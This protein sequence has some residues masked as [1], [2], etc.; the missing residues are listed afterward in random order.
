MAITHIAFPATP[1]LAASE[2]ALVG[3][4]IV[5]RSPLSGAEQ[6][7]Q[8]GA[9]RW[10][11]RYETPALPEGG[12]RVWRAF[13]ASLRGRGVP[14]Y[15]YDPSFRAYSGFAELPEGNASATRFDTTSYTWD[16]SATPPT[17]DEKTAATSVGAPYVREAGQ[18][19]TV[20]KTAGW[21]ATLQLYAGEYVS[22]DFTDANGNTM[23]ALHMIKTSIRTSSS[24]IVNLTVE[25]PIRTAPALNQ[26]LVVDN[27]S[28]SMRLVSDD[29]SRWSTNAGVFTTF[30]MEA[31]QILT[32][33]ETA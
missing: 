17:F 13:L 31:E 5:H 3:A 19:G 14:F 23:R 25:P 30:S 32:A 2:F 9:A 28:C 27:P 18:T 21:E 11:A 4:S 8:T 26:A 16:R 22:F 33:E 10:R 29:S 24:G 7:S 20:L 12:A 6:V 15:G 1:Y